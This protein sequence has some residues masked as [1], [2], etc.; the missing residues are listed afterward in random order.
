MADSTP[1]SR[2]SVVASSTERSRPQP[3]A[4]GHLAGA[5]GRQRRLVDLDAAAG[6]PAP[7]AAP[8]PR[9]P[10]ALAAMACGQVARG[11]VV[12][13]HGLAAGELEGRGG[14]QRAHH[15]QL[16]RAG[17]ALGDLLESVEIT[18]EQVEGPALVETGP[19]DQPPAAGLDVGVQVAGQPE[20][21]DRPPDHGRQPDRGPAA[22]A[23]RAARAAG[24]RPPWWPRAGHRRAASPH[25]SPDPYRAGRGL[26]A[27][28]SSADTSAA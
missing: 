16:D 20:Q 13:E 28:G 23:G 24:R 26:W 5:D 25:R 21:R 7:G 9:A 10:P 19:V 18:V 8:R 12:G 2:S 4:V 17:P 27:A 6:P 15:R 1:P 11:A 3:L 22:R 14:G